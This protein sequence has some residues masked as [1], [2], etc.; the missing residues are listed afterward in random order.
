M[1]GFQLL[2]AQGRKVLIDLTVGSMREGCETN[3]C[4]PCPTGVTGGASPFRFHAPH[5]LHY[6]EV[7]LWQAGCKGQ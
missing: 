2:G 6:H 3:L 4:L 7:A 5:L 1:L